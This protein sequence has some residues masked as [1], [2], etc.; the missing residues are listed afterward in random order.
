LHFWSSFSK[1][2]N[3]MILVLDANDHPSTT[4]P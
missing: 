4:V 2:L 3:L 1:S